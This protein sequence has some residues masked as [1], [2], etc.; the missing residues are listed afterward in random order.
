MGIFLHSCNTPEKVIKVLARMGLSVSLTSIHRAIH[1]LKSASFDDISTLGRTRLVSYAYDNIDVKFTTG[2]PT[3]DDG[4]KDTL[5]HLTTATLLRLEHN[6]T[7]D[8]LRCGNQLWQK[9]PLNPHAT[10]RIEFIP[11]KTLTLLYGLHTE[12]RELGAG[13]LTRRGAYRAYLF[14]K[15][16]F[17]Y[18]PRFFKD[19]DEF[20]CLPP[21]IEQIPVRKTKQVP[22]HA[23]DIDQSKVSG[24]IDA[25]LQMLAQSGVGDS[26][27]VEEANIE[28]TDLEDVV[29]LVHGDLGTMERVLSAMERRAI[30]LTPTARL[31][32]VAFVPGLFHLRMAAAD[33]LWRLFVIP[34][35]AR[36]DAGSFW[37]LVGKLRQSRTGKLMKNA[38]FREQHELINH[39]GEVLRLDAWRVE[40]ERRGYSSLE[41]W[42]ETNPSLEDIEGIAVALARRYTEGE[43][44]SHLYQAKTRTENQRDKLCENTLR[45]HHYLML[46][47]EL[48]Y[49]MNEGDIGRLET[50]FA[51][52]I[53]IFRAVGK[54]KYANRMLLFVHQLYEVYPEGLR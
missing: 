32:F 6:V 53:L 4:P 7:I 11:H 37:S 51:P 30:D 36:K 49:A 25:L 3:S 12:D 14:K 21:S 46:Y 33:A 2:I 23:M 43:D 8:D 13:Q 16:L 45:T 27:T 40:V 17:S 24:N 50:M 34:A 5:V 1:S 35:A 48:S 29:Q 26:K 22:M 39:V 28:M 20:L 54:H 44:T 15:S 10:H 47:E 31:Q 9:N 19:L 41:N 52:W 42:A 38:S 18:G